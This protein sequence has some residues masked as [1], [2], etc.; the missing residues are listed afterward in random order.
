MNGP[1]H[2]LSWPV[3]CRCTFGDWKWHFIPICCSIFGLHTMDKKYWYPVSRKC[4]NFLTFTYRRNQPPTDSGRVSIQFVLP[5]INIYRIFMLN[6]PN[7]SA[8]PP[9]LPLVEY[10][11]LRDRGHHC[12]S[13]SVSRF[14]FSILLEDL[15]I[16][17]ILPI[18]PILY[19]REPRQVS[20]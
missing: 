2:F 6:L 11:T 16:L 15:L 19:C 7:H 12:L 10:S 5:P 17:Q 20:S 8:Q 14:R 1:R 3:F 4:D 18:L 13:V 9:N